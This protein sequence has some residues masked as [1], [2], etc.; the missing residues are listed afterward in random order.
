MNEAR[1]SRSIT[2]QR[3]RR[4]PVQLGGGIRTLDAVAEAAL[5]WGVDRVILGTVAL[6]E[7]GAGETGGAALSRDASS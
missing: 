1:D 7:P 5:G 2:A 4:V 3:G 6:R